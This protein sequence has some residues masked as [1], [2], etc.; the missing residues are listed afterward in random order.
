MTVFAALLVLITPVVMILA[1]Y[2]W[3]DEK[4]TTFQLSRTLCAGSVV[5]LISSLVIHLWPA[6]VT[7]VIGTLWAL[8]AIDKHRPRPIWWDGQHETIHTEHD[9]AQGDS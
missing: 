1:A 6:A 4:I 2:A 7:A 8:H 3:S 9:T 5:I